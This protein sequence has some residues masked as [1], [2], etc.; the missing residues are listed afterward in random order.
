MLLS[1]ALHRQP[2]CAVVLSMLEGHV[3]TYVWS[4]ACRHAML[5]CSLP[6]ATAEAVAHA[7][8]CIAQNSTG[9][10]SLEVHAAT[11]LTQLRHC[12]VFVLGLQR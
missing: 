3:P 1:T 4:I 7:C 10:F 6:I 8:A 2:Q 9:S 11:N 12:W 5:S